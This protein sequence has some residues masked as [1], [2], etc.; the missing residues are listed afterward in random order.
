MPLVYLD[1]NKQEHI[2]SVFHCLH[3]LPVFYKRHYKLLIFVLKAPE[4]PC[5]NLFV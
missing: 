2:P 3:C 1:K 5:L 4:F